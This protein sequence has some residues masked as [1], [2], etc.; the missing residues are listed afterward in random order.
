M[1]FYMC[2]VL[3]PLLKKSVYH[4]LDWQLGELSIID[5]QNFVNLFIGIVVISSN[6]F[7]FFPMSKV[8]GEVDA[9]VTY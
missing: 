3:Y 9:C 4:L 6:F 2:I 8:E 5:F 7:F 1:I